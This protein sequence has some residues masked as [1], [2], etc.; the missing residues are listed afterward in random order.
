VWQSRPPPFHFLHAHAALCLL[1]L[2]LSTRHP[3]AL[4][5]TTT[6]PLFHYLSQ[7]KGSPSTPLPV[8]TGCSPSHRS[9]TPGATIL[10]RHLPHR[11]HHRSPSSIDLWPNQE[12]RKLPCRALL[13]V[14]SR[15]YSGSHPS[16]PPSTTSPLLNLMPSTALLSETS[17]TQPPPTGSPWSRLPPRQHFVW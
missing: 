16:T 10:H 4:A 9:V 1:S 17:S 2:P 7:P 15:V 14:N 11:A 5:S 3:C 6:T 12:C 8:A 13:L